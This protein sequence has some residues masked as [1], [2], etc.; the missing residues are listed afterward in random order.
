MLAP[1]KGREKLHAKSI[2]KAVGGDTAAA[3]PAALRLSHTFCGALVLAHVHAHV[4]LV[5]MD[6]I[7]LAGF[8]REGASLWI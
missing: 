3:C 1:E 7:V 6:F 4:R 2:C 8:C 5:T